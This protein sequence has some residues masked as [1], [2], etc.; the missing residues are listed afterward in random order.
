MLSSLK[1]P[2][3]YKRTGGFFP[4][5]RCVLTFALINV[6]RTLSVCAG[7]WCFLS[8]FEKQFNVFVSLVHNSAAH[9]I[10]Y[11]AFLRKRATKMRYF[12]ELTEMSLLHSSSSALFLLFFSSFVFF[13]LLFTFPSAFF[14]LLLFLPSLFSSFVF[15]QSPV[16]YFLLLLFHPFLLKPWGHPVRL[17][18]L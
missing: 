9:K 17:T 7:L 10:K 15:F 5:S 16:Y 3:T 1:D 4:P 6:K 2:A 12:L 18:R 8:R 13:H 14:F 11:N